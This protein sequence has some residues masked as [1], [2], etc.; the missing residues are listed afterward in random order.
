MDCERLDSLAI[1]LIDPD[2]SSELDP[3]VQREAEEH[4]ASC[5]RCTSALERLR[6][7]LRAGAELGLEDPSSLLEARILAAAGAVKPEASF[8]RRL[9]RAVSE[10]LIC[11]RSAS[12]A[13]DARFVVKLSQALCTSSTSDLDRHGRCTL[14]SS[15]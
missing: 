13:T 3:R 1:D 2:G 5:D 7:G 8:S 6:G 14:V 11:T 15:R 10:T 9:S 12:V 4:L